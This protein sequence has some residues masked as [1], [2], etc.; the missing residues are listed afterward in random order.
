MPYAVSRGKKKTFADQ[1]QITQAYLILISNKEYIYLAS[2]LYE[3]LKE[4]NSYCFIFLKLKISLQ[5]LVFKIT[6]TFLHKSEI[7]K[8]K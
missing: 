2:N 4:T 8:I 7:L 6:F 1:N 3:A 5:S